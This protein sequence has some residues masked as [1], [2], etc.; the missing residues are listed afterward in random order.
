MSTKACFAIIKDLDFAQCC[1]DVKRWRMKYVHVKAA[2]FCMPE[3]CK[4]E[5]Y[6]VYYGPV[7]NDTDTS[8]H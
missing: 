6:F 5:R 2:K 7:T 4:S 1:N 3:I 8:L